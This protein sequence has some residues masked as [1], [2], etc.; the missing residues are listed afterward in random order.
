MYQDAAELWSDDSLSGCFVALEKNQLIPAIDEDGHDDI[1]KDDHD[2]DQLVLAIDHQDESSHKN[3][4]IWDSV[5]KG[6]GSELQS[7]ISV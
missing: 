7:V 6:C 4:N 2:V 1:D 3:S 5:P